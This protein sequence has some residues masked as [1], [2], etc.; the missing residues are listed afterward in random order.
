MAKNL[1][2]DRILTHLAQI[3]AVN[4]FFSKIWLRQSLDVVVSYHHVQYQT[5]TNDPILRN[6]DRRTRVIS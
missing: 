5:K 2:S 1:V 3:R 6:E 4:F